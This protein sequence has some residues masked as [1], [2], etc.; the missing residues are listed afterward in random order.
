MA[1][2][3]SSEEEVQW[4]INALRGQI[5]AVLNAQAAERKSDDERWELWRREEE[6]DDSRLQDIL[7]GVR[8]GTARGNEGL[9]EVSPSAMV[10]ESLLS[11]G[12][13]FG[14]V[15][16]FLLV[17]LLVLRCVRRGPFGARAVTYRVALVLVGAAAGFLGALFEIVPPRDLLRYLLQQVQRRLASI[18]AA[19]ANAATVEAAAEPAP[20][21]IM[22]P[23]VPSRDYIALD[24]DDEVGRPARPVRPTA[25]AAVFGR[26]DKVELQRL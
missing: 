9:G 23:A 1:M 12:G 22:A 10:I 15:G 11:A 19:E 24:V 2:V 3:H 20:A 5:V 4:Q 8:G 18:A 14:A 21:N 26:R 17:T 13:T 7:A 25:V 16:L 6:K